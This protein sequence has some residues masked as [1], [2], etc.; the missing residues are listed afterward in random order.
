MRHRGS[1]YTLHNSYRGLGVTPEQG[2]EYFKIMPA[3]VASPIRPT[4]IPKGIIR[5]QRPA[6]LPAG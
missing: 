3:P 1:A 6:G 4:L 2:Q 5:T